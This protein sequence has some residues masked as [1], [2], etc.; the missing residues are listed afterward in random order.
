MTGQVAEA[1]AAGGSMGIRYNEGRVVV[2]GD[3]YPGAR[4]SDFSGSAAARTATVGMGNGPAAMSWANEAAAFARS[5]H[6]YVTGKMRKEFI[7]SSS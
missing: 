1:N 7:D 5:G 3:A 2:A 4:S 6:N